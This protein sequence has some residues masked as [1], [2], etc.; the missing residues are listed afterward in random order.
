M[1]WYCCGCYDDYEVEYDESEC[2]FVLF[3]DMMMLLFVFFMV[4]FLI[5]FVNTFK[6]EVL[7]KVFQDVFLGWV[8]LGG[9]V[10]M[11]MG[12]DEEFKQVMV[13]FL[14]VLLQLFNV[15]LMYDFV[16]CV[17]EVVVVKVEEEE[18]QK[19]KWWIDKLVKDV[20][21]KGCVLI[22]IISCGLVVQLLIDCVFFDFGQVVIKLQVECLVVKFL[23]VVCDECMYL[24]EVQGYMD[25][26]L[27]YSVCYMLNFVLFG[28]C[29]VVVIDDF[30]GYGVFVCCIMFVGDLVNDFVDINLMV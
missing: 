10:I 8:L 27:I 22:M 9:K 18:F 14:F 15:L 26:Q 21:F 30:V 7:Q 20:G 1:V 23:V 5:L 12:F 29:V 2:W 17:V 24:I 28:V 3:V 25:F 4:L 19:F 6:F 11:Q 16:D 13:E